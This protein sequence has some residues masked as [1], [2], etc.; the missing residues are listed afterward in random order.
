M[1]VWEDPLQSLARS[2]GHF[3]KGILTVSPLKLQK[4][5]LPPSKFPAVERLGKWPYAQEN[6]QNKSLN[7]RHP[8]QFASEKK[9]GV[10]VGCDFSY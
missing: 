8:K 3:H 1:S 10:L 9:S 2:K 4:Q 7:F 6:H 5:V